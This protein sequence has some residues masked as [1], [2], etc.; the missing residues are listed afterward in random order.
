MLLDQAGI[1]GR[2]N[3]QRNGRR[4]R[5]RRLGSLMQALIGYSLITCLQQAAMLITSPNTICLVHVGKILMRKQNRG[6]PGF[7]D[8]GNPAPATGVPSPKRLERRANVN[9]ME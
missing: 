7:S 1:L 4:L 6:S 5:F 8:P 9:L 2:A 3:I